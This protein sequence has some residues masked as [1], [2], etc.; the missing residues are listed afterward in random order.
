MS[1]SDNELTMLRREVGALRSEIGTLR[2]D[3]EDARKQTADTRTYIAKLY[4]MI[5]REAQHNAKHVGKIY[6]MIASI[7]VQLKAVIKKVL[8][9]FAAD[10]RQIDELLKQYGKTDYLENF[11]KKSDFRL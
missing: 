4:D 2:K 11:P 7:F 6:G 5:V 3:L 8:P 1:N 9:G 10:Q